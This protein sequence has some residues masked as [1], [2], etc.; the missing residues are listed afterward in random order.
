MPP[1][2]RTLLFEAPSDGGRLDA[3]LAERCPDISRSRL[4]RLIADGLVTVDGQP[5]RPAQQVRAG[6][7]VVVEAPEPEPYRLGGAGLPLDLVYEDDDLLVVD[8]PAGLVVHP[9]AGHRGDTLADAL[10][11]LA[12]RL[13]GVGGPLRAGIVH[14]LDKDTSG[15]IVVAKHES[16][17]ARLAAQFQERGVTKA[18]TALVHGYVTPA[19]ALVEARIGRD[20][21]HR[22]R[23]AL[24]SSG[25]EAMTRY[26]VTARYDGYSLLDVRPTTGRTHQIRVHMAA[27]GH[28]VAGDSTYGSAEERVGR[29]FLHARMLG[30][31]QPTT[32][33]RLELHSALPQELQDFQDSLG[34]P[35]T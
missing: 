22:Q 3:F 25:R 28:P 13:E 8:K 1:A 18:Y 26:R 32:G 29:H 5:S 4:K 35:R 2:S 23:M 9:G 6:Q 17:H 7:R 10:A 11:A 24:V 20:P 14:R 31:S 34:R 27:L 15:L 12:P 16:A 33:E 30:F 21:A 19:E